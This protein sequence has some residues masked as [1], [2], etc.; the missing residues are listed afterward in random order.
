LTFARA[1]DK[2][3][4]GDSGRSNVAGSVREKIPADRLHP[5]TV[6]SHCRPGDSAEEVFPLDQHPAWLVATCFLALLRF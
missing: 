5:K 6:Y 2:V 3:S 1:V 4:D